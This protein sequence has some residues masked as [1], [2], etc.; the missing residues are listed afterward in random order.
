MRNEWKGKGKKKL[1]GI[2]L[3]P[4]HVILGSLGYFGSSFH[5]R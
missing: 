2:R 5:S 1:P 3:S 4:L